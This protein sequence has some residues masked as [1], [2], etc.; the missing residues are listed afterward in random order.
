MSHGSSRAAGSPPFSPVTRSAQGLYGPL[1]FA[2][3]AKPENHM[4]IVKPGIYGRP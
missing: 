2:P 1:G 3:V 4:E